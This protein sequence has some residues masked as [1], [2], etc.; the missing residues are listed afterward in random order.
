MLDRLK[1]IATAIDPWTDEGYV[2][3]FADLREVLEWAHDELRKTDESR[4]RSAG[5]RQQFT[6]HD[7]V[8]NMK[9]E[10]EHG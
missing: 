1:K 3:A 10:R 8:V 5:T 7:T 4:R 9:E 2:L 6:P